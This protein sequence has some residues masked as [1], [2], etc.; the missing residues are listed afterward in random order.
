[1]KPPGHL[2]VRVNKPHWRIIVDER[3]QLKVSNFFERKNGVVEPTCELFY[4]WK[5][6]VKI[7]RMDG[8]GKNIKLKKRTDSVDWKLSIDYE[9]TAR[10]TPQQNH[11]A[12]I[13]FTIIGNRGRA[14]MHHANVPEEI[15]YKLYREAFTTAT[16][17]DGLKVIAIDGEDETRYEHWCGKLPRFAKHLRT[18]GEAG[19]VKTIT[20]KVS[21]V[22][23]R[24]IQCMFVGCA[25][26]HDGDVYR[27]WN[28]ETDRVMISRDVI[29]LKRMSFENVRPEVEEVGPSIEEGA[30]LDTE[31]GTADGTKVG[32]DE[33]TKE[34]AKDG[35]KEGAE[36]GITFDTGDETE[37]G[38]ADG[39][40]DG[41]KVGTDEGTK[42]G[43]K[44]GAKEGAE[45][46]IT[47]DTG[48]VTEEETVPTTTD[49]QQMR[50]GRTTRSGRS[51]YRPA[52]LTDEMNCAELTFAE[53][54]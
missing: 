45:E 8:A 32:A 19:T 54:N 15:R 39:A 35:T 4:K 3:T 9:I 11:L 50:R 10:N 5:E 37:E 28:P 48:D 13:A 7:A 18:W 20:T 24:G 53:K 31:D 51:T 41:T 30:T 36:E 38:T 33:G 25:M 26:N 34:G 12:E 2:N 14:L 16:H 40:A 21:K 27:M 43:A 22:L 49:G 17:L 23:D 6:V 1:V 29:W 47:F 52:R 46:G 44:D 42:V